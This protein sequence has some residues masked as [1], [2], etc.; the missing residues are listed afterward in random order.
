MS[1]D[2]TTYTVYIAFSF[3]GGFLSLD[4]YLIYIIMWLRTCDNMRELSLHICIPFF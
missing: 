1:I 4:R 2:T 3:S